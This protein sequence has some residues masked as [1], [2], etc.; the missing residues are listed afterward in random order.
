[1]SK[2]D[3]SRN[4]TQILQQIEVDIWTTSL[5]SPGKGENS[6]FGIGK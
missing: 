4:A 3:F 5:A 6:H 1:M 2:K